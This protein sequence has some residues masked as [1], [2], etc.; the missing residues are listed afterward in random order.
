MGGHGSYLNFPKTIYT[1]TYTT[2]PILL[3]K[4]IN[5]PPSPILL[6]KQDS[7]FKVKPYGMLKYV[8]TSSL[9]SPRTSNSCKPLSNT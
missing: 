2:S 9:P 5:N 1:Y 8:Y 6:Q 3:Q 7:N 4:Q